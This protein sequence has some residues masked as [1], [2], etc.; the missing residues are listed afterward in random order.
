[1]VSAEICSSEDFKQVLAL[2]KPTIVFVTWV[3]CG[4]CDDIAPFFEEL[5]D[6]YKDF[7]FAETEKDSS[8][9]KKLCKKHGLK[10]FRSAPTD[11]APARAK[12][13]K[14]DSSEVIYLTALDIPTVI[15]VYVAY[16]A[17]YPNSTIAFAGVDPDPL[18][19]TLGPWGGTGTAQWNTWPDP[20][21]G[22]RHY[23][24]EFPSGVTFNVDIN[25]GAQAA[26]PGT[27]VGGGWNGFNAFKCVRDNGRVLVTAGTG[28]VNILMNCTRT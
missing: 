16:V 22:N 26:S 8:I 25:P 2:G 10:S 24:I 19:E 6:T 13:E 15:T 18:D 23:D 28:V 12:L 3:A 11:A 9:G 4:S 17:Y 27:I 14:R 21:S 1:M 7:A 5:S 20:C